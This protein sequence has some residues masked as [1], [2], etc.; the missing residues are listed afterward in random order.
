M[1][2]RTHGQFSYFHGYNQKWPILS[3]IPKVEAITHCATL[4]I[5]GTQART[6]PISSTPRKKKL[7]LDARNGRVAG[8]QFLT[9]D[10][11]KTRSEA[12]MMRMPTPENRLPHKN[13]LFDV[14]DKKV[15]HGADRRQHRAVERADPADGLSVDDLQHILRNGKLLMA[16]PLDQAAVTVIH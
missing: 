5:T 4:K 6:R 10:T 12:T 7:E 2:Q 13:H 1:G 15:F 9:S 16:P 8:R 3:A 14:K 11:W